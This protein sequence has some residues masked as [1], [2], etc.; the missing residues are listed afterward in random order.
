[1]V[2]SSKYKIIF[3]NLIGGLSIFFILALLR[4]PILANS[5]QL[6]TPDE[7]IFA[8]QILDLYNGGPLFFYYDVVKYF[9]IFN[10]LAAI[11]FF[12]DSRRWCAG[13]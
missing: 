11:P 2:L 5:D 4:F 3:F 13:F 9:G 7:A 1:M 12:L 10:G 6:L 8:Y